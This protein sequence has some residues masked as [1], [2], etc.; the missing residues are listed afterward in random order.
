[1]STDPKMQK[2]SHSRSES[3]IPVCLYS[4]G[5]P[6]NVVDGE[7]MMGRLN[8]RGFTLVP[9]AEAAAVVVINTCA[10][11]ESA[12]RE[13]IDEIL[14][15]AQLK[16][17]G[18]LKFL[19][20]AGCLAERHGTDL[21]KEIPEI[22]ALI[23]PGQFSHI[24]E[25]L[26]DLFDG[27]DGLIQ[28]GKFEKPAAMPKRI[29][30][31]APHT[32][33]VKIAEG[34]SH[35]C[36]FC[37]IPQLRGPQ[38]SRPID[39]IVTEVEALAAEGV[40]EVIL[41]A[42]DTTAYGRD[43]PERPT[44]VDLLDRLEACEGPE[45]IRVLYGHLNYWSPPLTDR[46]GRGG[47]VLPYIDLPIQHIS[48]K[49][50]HRMGRRIGGREIRDQLTTIR[51]AIPNVVLRTTVMVG[52]PG[53]GEEEFAELINFLQEFPFDRLGAFAYS[54]EDGTPAAG[55]E[56]RVSREIA[57]Q[58]Q[59]QLLELQK[60]QGRFRGQQRKGE[61]VD[62]LIEGVHA[63]KD[64]AIGRSY[65][66]AP[67]ID[68]VIYVKKASTAAGGVEPGEFMPVQIVGAGPYDFVA[69]PLS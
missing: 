38:R 39:G 65:G 66:E 18:E 49:V 6:K 43:L 26:D 29:R 19:V 11:I 8:D 5:C 50:L 31:G 25:L 68:G 3:P 9:D 69:R 51:K 58:R 48:D 47:R 42:Q 59:V 23:G 52:H 17:S 62:L 45:W 54:P 1:M 44:I 63:D 37:L 56:D 20:V 28:I 32:T 67:D 35:Q 40:R 12:Q 15:L 41:V 36:T 16:V 64:Y 33:Y 30:S 7:V 10:F 46:F 53:E 34:C 57:D 24:A 55:F 22:D 60:S 21:I 27:G 4:L 61:V 14:E 13:A 2:T